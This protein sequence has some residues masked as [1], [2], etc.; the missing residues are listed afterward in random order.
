MFEYKCHALFAPLV[1]G[2]VS[3]RDEDEQLTQLLKEE[4]A[5]ISSKIAA[6]RKDV[7][8]QTRD[9]IN[10]EMCHKTSSVNECTFFVSS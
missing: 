3:T 5:Q 4:E 1:A 2:S 10:I 9:R 8:T 6:L 7:R